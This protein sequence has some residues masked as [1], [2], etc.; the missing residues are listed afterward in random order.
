[1]AAAAAAGASAPTAGM[2]SE[3]MRRQHGGSAGEVGV[4]V[5]ALRVVR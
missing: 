5:G 4:G 2:P 1:M 3:E